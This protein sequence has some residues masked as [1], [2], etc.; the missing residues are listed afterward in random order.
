MY[1]QVSGAISLR[2]WRHPQNVVFFVAYVSEG[3]DYRPFLESA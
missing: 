1:D 2:K 3:I